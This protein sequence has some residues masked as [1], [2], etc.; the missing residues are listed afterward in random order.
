MVPAARVELGE[1]VG[2]HG[3]RGALRVRLYGDDARH[4]ARAESVFLGSGA[5]DVAAQERG[6][7]GVEPGRTREAI[8]HLAGVESREAAGALA[9]LLILADADILETL[10]EG[11]YYWYQLIGCEVWNDRGERCGRVVGCLETGAHDIIVVKGEDGEERLVPAVDAW[12]REVDLDARRIVCVEAPNERSSTGR[13]V[14]IDVI[15]I[16][17][18]L[19]EPFAATSLLGEAVRSGKVDLVAHDLREFAEGPHRSV[20]DAPYGGGPGMVMTPEPLVAAI[21]AAAGPKG[22]ER[23]ARVL[24]M[25]PQGRRFDHRAAV[26]L[27]EQRHL[28]L[29]CGRYEGVDQR[30][31]DLAVDEEISIG[32]YV[33]AG[34]ESAA[35]VL[36]E[37]VTRLVPGVLGNPD[38]PVRESFAGD[39]LEGPHYTRPPTFRGLEVPAVLRGGHHAEI[40]R[41]RAERARERTQERRPDLLETPG[42]REQMNRLDMIE[43]VSARRDLP[44]FRPGDTLRVHVKVREGEKERTQVFEGVCIRRRGGGTSETF[45]VR[46]V[47]YGVGVE[48]IFP[49]QAPIVEKVEIQ[50]SRSRAALPPL[51]PPR[52]PRQEG[53]APLEGA[54]P[55]RAGRT[56]GRGGRNRRRRGGPGRGPRGRSGG[57]GRC[58]ARG[59]GR[60]RRAR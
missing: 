13:R 41:W 26:E 43:R 36:I 7:V 38:S 56:R 42:R 5:D 4:L 27:A 33:L 14:R 45:T 9:G 25:C 51:L 52:S 59:G 21:E 44:P 54:G 34:G 47:S 8:V 49:V 18:E 57:R 24:L 12:L 1:V 2:S 30:A 37:A 6:V 10:P 32:D 58:S 55:L 50:K 28:V 40:E 23:R 16:F 31:I 46:K 53:A 15:T 48:R 22:P 3:L 19:V 35:V 17:P 60:R 29:V 20:D 11:E 39:M